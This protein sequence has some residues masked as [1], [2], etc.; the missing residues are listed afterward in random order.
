MLVMGQASATFSLAASCRCSIVHL[1]K[2]SRVSRIVL[3]VRHSPCAVIGF[4]RAP[5]CKTWGRCIAPRPLLA[6]PHAQRHDITRTS[7]TNHIRVAFNLKEQHH[8]IH[9]EPSTQLQTTVH[10]RLLPRI[11]HNRSLG[12]GKV[13]AATTSPSAKPNTIERRLGNASFNSLNSLLHRPFLLPLRD[14]PT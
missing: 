1:A 14:T 6:R 12:I 5:W 11:P 10:G 13:P 9:S 2:P 7:D 8:C 3:W 4:L